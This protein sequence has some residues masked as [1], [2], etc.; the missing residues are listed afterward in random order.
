MTAIWNGTQNTRFFK[1]Q[2]FTFIWVGKKKPNLKKK[3]CFFAYTK[4]KF[5]FFAY[6][7]SIW[8]CFFYKILSILLLF[9]LFFY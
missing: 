5:D 3:E 6:T 2:V 8:V 4:S 9:G 1:N 7:T